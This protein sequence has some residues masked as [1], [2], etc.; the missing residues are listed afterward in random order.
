MSWGPLL[1]VPT[2][3]HIIWKRKSYLI[4]PTSVF[5]FLLVQI[6][7]DNWQLSIQSLCLE[8]NILHWGFSWQERKSPVLISSST[9]MHVKSYREL[10]TYTYIHVCIKYVWNLYRHIFIHLCIFVY[11]HIYIIIHSRRFPNCF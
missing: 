5:V 10:Y 9:H 8:F 7:W 6:Y 1:T 4:D 2:S 3:L 11:M